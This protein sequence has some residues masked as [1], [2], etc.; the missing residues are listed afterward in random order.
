AM[1]SRKVDSLYINTL[2]VP[3]DQFVEE[4]KQRIS[5][6]DKKVRF[7]AACRCQ[8]DTVHLLFIAS[9]QSRK[10]RFQIVHHSREQDNIGIFQSASEMYQE[11]VNALLF[12]C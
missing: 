12:T 4:L 6:L 1:F 5:A 9:H 7:S 10:F 11:E 8:E 3:G 2:W